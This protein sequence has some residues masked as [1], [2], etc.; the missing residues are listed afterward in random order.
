MKMQRRIFSLDRAKDKEKATWGKQVAGAK[1]G[2]S[3]AFCISIIA[4]GGKMSRNVT[5]DWYTKIIP[6]SA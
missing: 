3:V 4:D 2:L 1:A 5:K 6:K